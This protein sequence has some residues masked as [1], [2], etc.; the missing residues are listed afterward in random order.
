M[1][2]SSELVSG[3]DSFFINTFDILR[4]LKCLPSATLSE[5]QSRSEDDFDTLGFTQSSFDEAF[6]SLKPD[7]S[8]RYLPGL[9]D[10]VLVTNVFTKICNKTLDKKRELL[11]AT[12][13]CMREL[14]IPEDGFESRMAELL[15]EK[16]TNVSLIIYLLF[17]LQ[18]KCFVGKQKQYI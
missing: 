8:F 1:N 5:A 3:Y 9:T 6:K 11:M 17:I 13:C 15:H 10:E 2:L 16:L 12:Y 4:E 18:K 7:A 14:S